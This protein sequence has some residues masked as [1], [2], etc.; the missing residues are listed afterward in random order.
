MSP[1]QILRRPVDVKTDL[2]A[3]GVT[4]WTCLAGRPPFEGDTSLGILFDKIE[5]P[6]PD[7]RT[8]AP[9]TPPV[10]AALIDRMTEKDPDRRVATPTELIDALHAFLSRPI[11]PAAIVD[12]GRGSGPGRYQD[13]IAALVDSSHDAILSITPDGT[14]Q[15]W[16]A[17]A[18]RLFGYRAGDA[19][20]RPLALLAPPDRAEGVAAMLARVASGDRI[21]PYETQAVRHDGRRLDISVAWSP[22]RD[23]SGALLGASIIARDVTERKRADEAVRASES[24]FRAVAESA[25]DAIISADRAGVVTYVN[26][27][28]ERIFGYPA[29]EIVGRPL[30]LLMPERFADAHRR[31]LA[32]FLST[33]EA[34]LI[35]RT[36]QVAGRR[37][38]GSEF[39]MEISLSTWTLSGEVY[40]TGIARPRTT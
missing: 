16:N 31:G 9:H 30:T 17:A 24:R 23:G 11:S 34:R 25:L 6:V 22:I 28:A 33:G 21:E 4:F 18:E 29:A 36:A 8:A 10:I 13:L 2:Y 5:H 32:R 40:F 7:V 27:A 38:D 12:A 39:P 19:V 20:G 26:A 14:I 15:S 37:R 1:E 3:L 35:G